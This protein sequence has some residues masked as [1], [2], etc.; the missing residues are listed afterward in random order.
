MVKTNGLALW[1]LTGMSV[2]T[3]TEQA[4]GERSVMGRKISK[5]DHSRV[6]QARL[7]RLEERIEKMRCV[8]GA[9]KHDALLI[10]CGVR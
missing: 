6:Q 3:S 8:R 5:E 9:L 4:R 1:V 2:C 7:D 10:W